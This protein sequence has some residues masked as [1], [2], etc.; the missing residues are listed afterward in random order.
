M[1]CLE[2]ALPH[3]LIEAARVE[4][5]SE[6]QIFFRIVLPLVRPAMAALAVLILHVYLERLLLGPDPGA[7]R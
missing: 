1:Q 4:G 5:A 7:E 3:E 6:F 2:K